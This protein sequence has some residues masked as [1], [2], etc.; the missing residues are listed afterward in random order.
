MASPD[1]RAVQGTINGPH[2]SSL[3]S[4]VP[5][6]IAD[7]VPAHWPPVQHPVRWTD[8]DTDPGPSPYRFAKQPSIRAYRSLQRIPLPQWRYLRC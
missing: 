3:G 7:A 6:A 4:A 2:P 5:G 8:V 1:G